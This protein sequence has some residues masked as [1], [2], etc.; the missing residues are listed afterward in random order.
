M[1]HYANNACALGEGPLWHPKRNT[2]IWFD[3]I[4][5][6]MFEKADDHQRQWQFDEHVSA[7]GWIDSD[8]VLMASQIGLWRFDLTTGNRDLVTPLEAD[9]PVTRSN[10]GRADPWGGFWIGTMG[11]LLEADAAAIYRYYKGELRKLVT[12]ITIS[13]AICFAPDKSCAYYTDTPTQKIMRI[14]L[15]TDSG[16]PAAQPVVAIDLTGLDG[17]PDGAVT[18][19]Q[20]NLWIALWGG[21]RVACYSAD[22]TH[23]QDVAVPAKQPTCPAFGGP[24][25]R[26]LMVT[27]AST[28]L[29]IA[30]DSQDGM[31]FTFPD[32]AQGLPEPRV[33]L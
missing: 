31:T 1:T 9:N 4:N 25:L 32:T 18:D 30:P 14:A 3:I 20:G 27:S 15:D 6:T 23:I 26:D 29:D 16:W 22:G 19:A 5:K 12:D 28:G 21:A 11:K 17:N 13:N 2:L 7:A 8:S 33:I 10:D 24:K